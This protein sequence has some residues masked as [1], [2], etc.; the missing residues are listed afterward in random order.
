[1]IVIDYFL[2]IDVRLHWTI[3]LTLLLLLSASSGNDP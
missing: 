3:A 2:Y 1:M